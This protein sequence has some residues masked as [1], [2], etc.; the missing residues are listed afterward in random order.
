M[1]AGGGGSAQVPA[2]TACYVPVTQGP[3]A[4]SPLPR[5]TWVS[6]PLQEPP[7]Q[8]TG[9]R[10]LTW[11]GQAGSGFRPPSCFP[12]LISPH[13]QSPES[14]RPFPSPG[15]KPRPFTWHSAPSWLR[16]QPAF[17]AVCL[18]LSHGSTARNSPA[19]AGFLRPSALSWATGSSCPRPQVPLGTPLP[20]EAVF[21]PQ[22][23]QGVVFAELFWNFLDTWL[24]TPHSPVRFPR[25]GS[26]QSY[27]SLPARSKHMILRLFTAGLKRTA[28]RD[29]SWAPLLTTTD[30]TPIFSR[31][32]AHS[33]HKHPARQGT[34]LGSQG[35]GRSSAAPAPQGA[36]GPA[37]TSD[38]Q[39]KMRTD[40]GQLPPGQEDA[41]GTRGPAG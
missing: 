30:R 18:S 4:S 3:A 34:A 29:S 40:D 22:G 32:P 1:K 17:S 8:V 7:T 9:I 31:S 35:E 19:P 27:P 41:C 25:P 28:P 14:P 39:E 20:Q 36:Y 10:E 33:P 38:V 13:H 12:L 37:E 6:P 5:H 2:L 23:P 16:P 15:T 11:P 26:F 21:Y 24:P